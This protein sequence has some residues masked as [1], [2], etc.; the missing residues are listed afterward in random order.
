MRVTHPDRVMIPD[1]Q[2][3]KR[4]LIDYYLAVKD[5]ILPHVAGRPLSLVRYPS[6]MDGDGFFQKHAM[7]GFPDAFTAITIE[8]K[9]GSAR[10][11]TI[12]DERGLVAAVQ[13]G[14]LELH[15]W[16]AHTETL[17]RPDRL[18]FDLDPDPAV[19]FAAVR[20]AAR[21][22]RARLAHLGLVSFPMATGGKGIHVVVPLTPHHGWDDVHAFAKAMALSLARDDPGLYLA[23]M[24]KARRKGRIFIDYLRNSRG[25][26]AIAPF[27]TR[28]RRGAPIAWPLSW[29]ALSRLKNA[30]AATVE[31]AARLLARRKHEAWRDYFRIGQILP[32][33]RPAG[34]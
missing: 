5:L 12:H 9:D 34:L 22:L 8:E 27:S 2:I 26:T 6:G 28:A 14:V 15:I 20:D 30:R 1:R 21:E 13:M 4:R 33:E 11:L 23:E 3:T 32:Q 10:Y 17:E 31:N 25:A 7:S 19:D 16:G 24:S 29:R 18:V